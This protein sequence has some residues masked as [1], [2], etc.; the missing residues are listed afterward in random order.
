MKN[1][2]LHIL[3]III[4]GILFSQTNVAT[5]GASFLEI[6][7]GA[8]SLSMGSAFVSVANDV[9]ALYWNPA[10]I[11]NLD[12]PSV[13]F[14]H[15][16]W[17]VDTEYYYGGA[18][19]PLSAADAIGFSYTSVGMDEMMVRTVEMPEGTGEKFDASNLAM[20]IAYARQLTDQ[21]SFGVQY[22]YVQEKIWQM[23]ASAS[24]I[25]IG[26]LFRT[27]GGMRIGMSISNF[28]DKM[29]MD[30]I[31][32]AIDHD[33]DET[34]YGNNDKIDGH[35][36]AAKWPMPLLFR[37]GISKDYTFSDFHRI[38]LSGDANHPN[39]NVEYVNAGI[40]YSYNDLVS[41]R[42]G[43]SDIFMEDAEQGLCYGAG[44]NYKIPRGPKVRFD[45]V[46]RSFGLF[47]AISGFSI[48]MTF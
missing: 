26:T 40:E 9:S 24:S 20:G 23:K 22:K 8:K 46:I 6:G 13:Q 27:S 33:V 11:V 15:S 30:G 1:L 38:T 37:F 36:D 7:S 44:I 48:D 25:D 34:I 42:M 16:P 28:G 12:R 35:M 45:Y 5:T 3:S 29:G 41:L 14:Y 2:R 4:T 10:G 31:N 43:Q 17:L 21:F 47:K 19:V 39:N 32:T 18:V